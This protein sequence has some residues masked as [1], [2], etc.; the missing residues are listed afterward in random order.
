MNIAAM[1][2]SKRV[3]FLITIFFCISSFLQNNMQNSKTNIIVYD[4]YGYYLYLPALYIYHDTKEFRFVDKHVQKYKICENFY[5]LRPTIGNKKSPLYNIGLS[6]IWTPFFLISHWYCKHFT[7]YAPDGM[8][9]PYQWGIF[10]SALLF[11]FIGFYYIRKLLL[12]LLFSDAVVCFVMIVIAFGTNY[13]YYALFGKEMTHIYLFGLYASFFYHLV[14]YHQYQ[15]RKQFI[16]ISALCAA[17]VLIRSSEITILVL[18]GLYG[19]KD[20]VCFFRNVKLIVAIICATVLL[21]SIQLMFYKIN[22][23]VWFVNGY[24]DYT[25]HLLHPQF[26]Y[27]LFG[28]TKGW[29]VYSP[30]FIFA[31][32]GIFITPKSKHV[33]RLAIG[34]YFIINC[35]VLF[36]WSDYT[37][38]TTFGCRPL[39]QSYSIIAVLFA[40]FFQKIIALKWMQR[41]LVGGVFGFFIVLNLF[42]TWQYSTGKIPLVN[43]NWSFYWYS[44]FNPNMIRQDFAYL[45]IEEKFRYRNY[46]KHLMY[47][48]DTSYHCVSKLSP[49]FLQNHAI[50]RISVHTDNIK[51]LSNAWMH[52]RF[53]AQYYLEFCSEDNMPSI[54]VEVNRGAQNLKWNSIGIP[55][56]MN[57]R[58][59]DSIPFFIKNPAL[60]IGDAINF[61]FTNNTDDSMVVS[62]LQISRVEL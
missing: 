3:L 29:L 13:Y 39:V 6:I 50:H 38:G 53:D 24:K 14:L 17:M 43:N 21:F 59:Y 34:V 31:C 9:Y 42:Q 37:Y 33:H 10:I 18:V 47:A 51:Q 20:A 35:Y 60:Q 61:Y 27:C 1:M 30:L 15:K 46:T 36:S 56:L 62:R 49:N 2:N 7:N 16:I 28:P 25:F 57:K 52:I 23:G 58:S 32:L 8:S 22:S 48:S 41:Y 5:Q 19:L 26:M 44:F 11:I 12:L 40:L 54:V 4:G 45:H 55:V